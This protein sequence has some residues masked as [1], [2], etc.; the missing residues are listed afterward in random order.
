MRAMGK[1]GV[2]AAV[3]WAGACN[4][5]N[6]RSLPSETGTAEEKPGPG[7]RGE[8]P[9][10]PATGGPKGD[11]ELY[12]SS[13]ARAFEVRV[14]GENLQGATAVLLRLGSLKAT[15]D[16]R[17]VPVSM[18]EAAVDLAVPNQAWLVGRVSVPEGAA[19]VHFELEFAQFGGLES[20]G[21][22]AAIEGRHIPI[23]WTAPV[24][25]LER[26]GHT[27]VHLDVGRSLIEAGSET[28][29]LIPALSIQY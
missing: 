10:P 25:W 14:R 16:G 2:V 26:N 24:S 9:T 13:T 18:E 20:Q 8:A 19:D 21:N 27:V 4:S 1:W 29:A 6:V 23:S 28:R 22:G 17:E 12:P 3:L 5:P 7:M 15:V 11:V